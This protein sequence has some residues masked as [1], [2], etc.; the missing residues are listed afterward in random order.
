MQGVRPKAIG[1]VRVPPGARA[2]QGVE[3]FYELT[4]GENGRVLSVVPM[5][6]KPFVDR[7][8]IETMSN[9]EF[10]PARCGHT[11]VPTNITIDLVPFMR[12]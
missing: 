9:W 10:E 7:I 2:R 3:L 11:P 8:A 1:P 12:Q 4:I 6:E 5:A